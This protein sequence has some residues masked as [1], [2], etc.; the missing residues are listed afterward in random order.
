MPRPPRIH[1]TTPKKTFVCVQCNRTFRS[2]A[3]RTRHINAKH[4]GL[5]VHMNSPSEEADLF[6]D[7]SSH[8]S[9]TTHIFDSPTR[10]LDTLNF[11][12]ASGSEF[13]NGNHIDDTPP[14]SP[15]SDH[16]TASTSMEYHP[17][18]NG[19]MNSYLWHL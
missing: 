6:S 7:I 18:L 11:G 13:N 8:L 19:K 12:A 14:R 10:D 15:S 9:P 3:G 17:H 5:Q 4:S 16:D 2:K 1:N